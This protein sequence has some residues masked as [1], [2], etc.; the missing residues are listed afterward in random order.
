MEIV[1]IPVFKVEDYSPQMMAKCVPRPPFVYLRYSLQ[2][3][4]LLGDLNYTRVERQKY[5][6]PQCTQLVLKPP[7][8]PSWNYTPKS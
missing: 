7:P 1:R 6:L 3:I 5:V 4:H 8:R 2:A